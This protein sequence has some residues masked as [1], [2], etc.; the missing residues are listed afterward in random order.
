VPKKKIKIRSRTV[1]LILRREMSGRRSKCRALGEKISA[2]LR[3]GGKD[4]RRNLSVTTTEMWS[5]REAGESL[6]D[7]KA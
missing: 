1:F 6:N 3:R 5:R 7:K 4:G 2:L